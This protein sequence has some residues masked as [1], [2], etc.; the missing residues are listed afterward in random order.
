MATG[1]GQFEILEVVTLLVFRTGLGRA[2]FQLSL[3]LHLTVPVQQASCLCDSKT[4]VALKC[5]NNGALF[6]NQDCSQEFIH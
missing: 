1:L 5:L 3:T 6:I 4:N 2:K